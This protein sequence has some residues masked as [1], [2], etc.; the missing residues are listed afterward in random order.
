MFR[1]PPR[2]RLCRALVVI[3]ACLL[4][5]AW[6]PRQLTLNPTNSLP[7]TLY[8][9]NKGV[10]PESI[11]RGD[12]VRFPFKSSVTDA[13]AKG[14]PVYLLKKAACLQGQVLTVNDRKEYLCDGRWLGRAKDHNMKGEVVQN[15]VWNGPVPAGKFFALADHKDSYDSR[16]YGFVDLNKVV[17]KAYP[18]F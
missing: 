5:S 14:Q 2:S 4:V 17:A 13:V 8:V 9:L 11:H 1:L 10:A 6:I 7:N 18:I 15:F 3:A 12:I 16:Y